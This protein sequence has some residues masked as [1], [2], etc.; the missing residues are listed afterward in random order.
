MGGGPLEIRHR[1]E[2]VRGRFQPQDV[3]AGR[4]RAGL[5][6]LDVLESPAPE[7]VHDHAGAEVRAFGE[8]DGLTG[9]EEREQPRRHGGGAGGEQ[10]RLTLRSA[11]ERSELPLSRD[12]RRVRV[13]R[14]DELA[15]LAV[16]I[17][18]DT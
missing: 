2:R 3:D 7:L 12:T 13:P 6:E 15:W 14:V 10:E 8:R 18:P 9:L 11:L 1:Q 16:E 5:V 4:R 17:R